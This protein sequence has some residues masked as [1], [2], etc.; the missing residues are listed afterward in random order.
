MKLKLNRYSFLFALLA[1]SG[2]FSSMAHYH[3]EGLE[4]LDHAN[5][6]H[7]VEYEVYCPIST[8]VS[9]DYFLFTS[10]SELILTTTDRFLFETSEQALEA[11]IPSLSGRSPPFLA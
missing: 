10:E 7:I 11:F 5:E 6:A 9:D 4:C 8:L 3:S 1:I 2:L